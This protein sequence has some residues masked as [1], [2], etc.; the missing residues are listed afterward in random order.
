MRANEELSC[1]C[2]ICRLGKL[3]KTAGLK[4]GKSAEPVNSPFMGGDMKNLK[5][6]GRPSDEEEKSPLCSFCHGVDK[7]NHECNKEARL[8][9]ILESCSPSSNE[10]LASEV[11]KAKVVAKENKSIVLK[12]K[13]GAPLQVTVDNCDH[14]APPTPSK[15]TFKSATLM[16]IK[17]RLGLRYD[18][19]GCE[20][21]HKSGAL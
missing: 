12:S 14:L 8:Y 6:Q 21:L 2:E 20:V 15:P 3:A 1:N 16:K 13:R 5:K 9:N 10:I 18:Y 19:F 4:V 11:I 7:K 17:S